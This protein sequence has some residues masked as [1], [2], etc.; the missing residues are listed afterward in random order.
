MRGEELEQEPLDNEEGLKGVA[1]LETEQMEPIFQEEMPEDEKENVYRPSTILVAKTLPKA[2]FTKE[3]KE[4][5]LSEVVDP[6]NLLKRSNEC[7][8]FDPI[9]EKYR[10]AALGKDPLQIFKPPFSDKDMTRKVN[11]TFEEIVKCFEKVQ[12]PAK[13]DIKEPVWEVKRKRPDSI[14]ACDVLGK[15]KP[16]DDVEGEAEQIQEECGQAEGVG[17]ENQADRSEM[18]QCQK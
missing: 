17:V 2:K 12:L 3:K 5:G 1:S 7:G 11:V 15:R 18:L 10:K 6:C 8:K 9:K 4:K 16:E 14:S 13:L